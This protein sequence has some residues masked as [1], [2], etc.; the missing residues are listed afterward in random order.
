MLRIVSIAVLALT[1][2]SAV[3]ENTRIAALAK[4]TDMVVDKLHEQNISHSDM[5]QDIID[6][7]DEDKNQKISLKELNSFYK[8]LGD[9][10]GYNLTKNDYK[11]I[12]EEFNKVDKD[13][14]KEVDKKELIHAIKN[15]PRISQM[16]NAV[17][18]ERWKR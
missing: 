10:W 7:L 4:M 11:L 12:E 6:Y 13:G 8:K 17:W 3:Y 2:V 18:S 16:Y 14:S 15:D 1:S 9:K 5:A